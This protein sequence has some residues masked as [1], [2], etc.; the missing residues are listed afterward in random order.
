[1]TKLCA[2]DMSGML[3]DLCPL[4]CRLNQRLW[5]SESF[6]PYR[7]HQLYHI[8]QRHWNK[9]TFLRLQNFKCSVDGI[10]SMTTLSVPDMHVGVINSGSAAFK[11]C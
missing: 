10:K 8:F 5:E 1:M 2:Y 3:E 9:L 7:A 6:I 4:L 11:T